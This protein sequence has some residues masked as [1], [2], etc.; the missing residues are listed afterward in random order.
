MSQQG[1]KVSL[2]EE[3][4]ERNF[5]FG[6]TMPD[7]AVWNKCDNK[8]IMCTNMR[9]FVLQNPRQYSLKWQIKKFEKYLKGEDVYHKN[10]DKSSYISLTGGEP[11]LHPDFLKFVAYLRKR[12]PDVQVTLLTN[13]KKFADQEFAKKFFAIANPPFEIAV[14]IHG[15]TAAKHDRISGAKG[16]FHRTLEGLK[17]I[18]RFSR[19]QKTEIRVVLIK[20]NISDFGDLVKM[21][22]KKLAAARDY[23][24]VVIH[25]EIEGIS[26]ENRQK[27]ALR[28]EDSSFAIMKNLNFIKRFKEF[29]LY[30]FPLCVL[31]PVLRRY[32]W[33]TLPKEERIY[34]KKCRGCVLRKNCLGLMREYYKFF[35]D[36]EIK[37]VSK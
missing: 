25:Y 17:N 28:F 32:A 16:S 14:S 13:G 20:Q 18:F 29:R 11:T 15:S 9:S 26:F 33:V 6:L 35:G 1:A 23:R 27:I 22:L 37:A 2:K 10:A 8:C 34:T 21:L 5:D 24:V 36:A 7:I 12:V 19:G 30:H 3:R 4:A 31:P